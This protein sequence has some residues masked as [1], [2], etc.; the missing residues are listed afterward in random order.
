MHKMDNLIIWAIRIF[1]S[2]YILSTW[3][4][5]SSNQ[6]CIPSYSS[7]HP[8][9]LTNIHLVLQLYFLITTLQHLD[10]DDSIQN[11][12]ISSPSFIK[13]SW[14]SHYWWC[15]YS[16]RGPYVTFFNVP[17]F[18]GLRSFNL[19]TNFISKWWILL[20]IVL[21]DELNIKTKTWQRVRMG[22]Q[23]LSG[24][25]KSPVLDTSVYHSILLW[26]TN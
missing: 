22:K 16:W 1:K 5:F 8:E 11:H 9:C 15:Q 23:Y 14:T 24:K 6:S 17:K 25:L 19:L 13:S 20:R 21:D 7:L 4:T 3:A 10:I 18:R 12:P 2:E 26:W